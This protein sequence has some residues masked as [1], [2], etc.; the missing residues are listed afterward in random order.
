[1]DVGS[2]QQAIHGSRDGSGRI[3]DEKRSKW[4]SNYMDLKIDQEWGGTGHQLTRNGV[5]WH[6]MDSGSVLDC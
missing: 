4:I 6:D 3:D 2:R 5:E 1:M